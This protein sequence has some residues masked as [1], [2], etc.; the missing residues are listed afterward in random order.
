[1]GK[2]HPQEQCP[3]ESGRLF[4]DCHGPKVRKFLTPEITEFY[5]LVVIPKPAHNTASIFEY[6]GKGT[7]VF[8]GNEVGL[9]LICG[10]CL[11]HLTEG[12]P[13]QNIQ[14]IV[15]RCNGCGEYNET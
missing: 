10:N 13:R 8:R 11:S 9:A 3:C 4:K 14:N 5:K 2:I 7:V 15:L 12:I 1:M 6:T